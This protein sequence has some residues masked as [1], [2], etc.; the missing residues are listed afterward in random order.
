V[1]SEA[2]ARKRRRG[3]RFEMA[4]VEEKGSGRDG[5]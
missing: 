5:V 4:K 3:K 1:W 2:L